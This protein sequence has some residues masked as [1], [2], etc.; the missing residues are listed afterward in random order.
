M[1]KPQD[2]VSPVRTDKEV[3]KPTFKPLYYSKI[4]S[5]YQ[6]LTDQMKNPGKSPDLLQKDFQ[7]WTHK[8][9]QDFIQKQK[10]KR[11]SFQ[12]SRKKSRSQF[13]DK[14]HSARQ[15]F[16]SSNTDKEE[17]KKFYHEQSIDKKEFYALGKERS[18]QFRDNTR[19]ERNDF[20]GLMRE[21]SKAFREELRIY[22]KNYKNW[23]K[24]GRQQS[25]EQQGPAP[26]APTPTPTEEVELQTTPKNQ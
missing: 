5:E 20:N 24:N 12:S 11:S 14:M 10:I 25:T 2:M 16:K 15:N 7:R 13:L 17:L 3:N 6:T 4:E 18:R 1:H 23:V 21:R 8:R 9:R 19:Q 22:K 26:E